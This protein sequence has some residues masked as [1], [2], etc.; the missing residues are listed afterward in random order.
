[1]LLVPVD[2]GFTMGQEFIRDVIGQIRPSLVVPMH[3]FGQARLERFLAMMADDYPSS[4]NDGPSI[5]L[6]RATL[7]WRRTI[8][9]PGPM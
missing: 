1:V 4:V 8:V 6:S 5:L 7:P 2:G 3:W 9:L